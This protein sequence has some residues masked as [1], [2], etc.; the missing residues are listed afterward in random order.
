[1]KEHFQ[2]KSMSKFNWFLK[3]GECKDNEI[4]IKKIISDNVDIIVTRFVRGCP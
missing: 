2:R 3:G 4:V 1:M